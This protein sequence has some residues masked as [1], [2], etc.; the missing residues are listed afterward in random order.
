MTCTTKTSIVHQLSLLQKQAL[1]WKVMSVSL[2][3]VM[4]KDGFR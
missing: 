2:L 1:K 4:V 3:E